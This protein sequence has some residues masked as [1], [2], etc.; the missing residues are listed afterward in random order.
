VS[1]RETVLALERERRAAEALRDTLSKLPDMD[2]ET[3]RDTIEGE[4]DLHGA[5]AGVVDLLTDTEIGIAGL[6]AHIETMQARLAR[7]T[8]R[9]D[10][11]RSAVEQAMVIGEIKT[12]ELPTGTLSLSRRAPGLIITDEARIPA[13][14][15]RPQDPALDKKALKEALKDKKDIPGATLSNGSLSLTIRRA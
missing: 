7:C 6:K 1:E 4:T 14:F 5:I 8:R 15:W 9:A 3:T 13:E 12:I 2:E 10:F 11:L